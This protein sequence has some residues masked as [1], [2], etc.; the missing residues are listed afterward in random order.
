MSLVY[1]KSLKKTSGVEA[2]TARREVF[3]DKVLFLF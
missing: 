3:K 1:L 2:E